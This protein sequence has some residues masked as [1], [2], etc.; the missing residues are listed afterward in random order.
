MLVTYFKDPRTLPRYRSG[1]A[2]LYVQDFIGARNLS[3][4]GV[5]AERSPILP[6]QRDS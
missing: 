2:N 1:F 4:V 3:R 6:L 5:I